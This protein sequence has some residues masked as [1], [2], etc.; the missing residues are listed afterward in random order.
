MLCHLIGQLCYL[1]VQ[2]LYHILE[3]V[4]CQLLEKVLCCLY[5][6]HVCSHVVTQNKIL[7]LTLEQSVGQAAGL[8]GKSIP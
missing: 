3:Q 7:C 2:V 1:L 5:K 6:E 4:L 8:C